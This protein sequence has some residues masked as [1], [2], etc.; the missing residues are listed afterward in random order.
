MRFPS[1]SAPPLYLTSFYLTQTFSIP[2][3]SISLKITL[4][5]CLPFSIPFSLLSHLSLFVLH[6]YCKNKNEHSVNNGTTTWIY[7]LKSSLLALTKQNGTIIKRQHPQVLTQKNTYWLVNF[8]LKYNILS[9]KITDLIN[10]KDYSSTLRSCFMASSISKD[11]P[12]F[13]KL[14]IPKH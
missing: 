4:T 10:K 1:H 12:T 6:L 14:C 7:T 5:L 8:P 11:L 9:I 3:Y 2:F 13:I